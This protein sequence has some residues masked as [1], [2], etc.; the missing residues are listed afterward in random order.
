MLHAEHLD[1][2]EDPAAP[3]AYLAAATAEAASYRLE[4]AI[5]M[6]RR[7]LEIATHTKDIVSLALTLGRLNLNTGQAA[8]A[9]EAFKTASGLAEDPLE[10]CK[11]LTG[12]AAADRIL[13]NIDDAF[14]SLDAAE[15]LAKAAEA[16]ALLSEIHYIRGNLHF[17]RGQREACLRQ[18]NLALAAAESAGELEWQARA[19]SG[20]GDAAY[21]QGRSRSAIGYFRKCIDIARQHGLLRIVPANQCMIGDSL[22]YDLKLVEAQA[23]IAEARALAVRIGDR[24][25]EM[26]ALQSESYV[27]WAS[28]RLPEAEAPTQAALTLAHALGARRYEAILLCVMAE[29]RVA[30]QRREE[31]QTMLQEAYAIGAET[32]YGF[33]GPIICAELAKIA[34]APEEGRAWIA[35][36]LDMLV[37]ARLAHND[38]FFR[39]AAIDW[40]IGACDWALVNR[41]SE[42][43]HDLTEDEPMPY[44][45]YYVAR[46][47]ALEALHHNP[48]DA[49]A[50]QAL[51]GL[52]DQAAAIDLRP[53]W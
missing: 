38:I 31:A 29:V 13:T 14:A 9:R 43:L 39:K 27:H 2:A 7:G 20:L 28:G 15:P 4:Q 40:G 45:D 44:V 32:G 11:A 22:L 1:R 34:A 16:Q 51:S 8:P 33:C 47:R 30:Q 5:A 3:L 42:E 36:G 6:T 52:N 10:Q 48:D 19:Y 24:F 18:H 41:M 37:N 49:Q 26:F 25:S 53:F 12:I 46:A 17:A 21:L 50:T 23:E 35:R